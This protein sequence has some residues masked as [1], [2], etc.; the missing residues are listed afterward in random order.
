MA[1]TGREPRTDGASVHGAAA[2]QAQAHALFG[3]LARALLLLA[4]IAA[5]LWFL[6]R[7]QQV[8]LLLLLVAVLAIAVT[9]PVSMLE[10]R[11]GW[12]RGAAL[13][14]V[15]LALLAL[16][17]GLLW[18]LV[19][20]LLRE[21]PTLTTQIAQIAQIAEQAARQAGERFGLAEEA[22]GQVDRLLAWAGGA[23]QEAWRFAGSLVAGLVLAIV[24]VAM[25]LYVVADPRPLLAGVLRAMPPHLRGRTAEALARG[26]RMVVAWVVANALIGAIKAVA[27]FLFLTYMGVP[28]ALPWSLLAFFSALVPQIGFYLMSIP[29]IMM[30]FAVDPMTALWVGLYFWT[31]STLLGNF[32]APHIQGERMNLHPAY[33][34]GMTVAFGYAFGLL[35]VLIAAPVA[36]FLKAFFDAFYLERQPEDERSDERVEAILARKP[37]AAG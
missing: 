15:S 27:A 18:L 28:G 1:E 24:T 14:A 30:A 19:P 4:G 3:A 29:P 21:L 5:L 36:G 26:S 8:V 11:R 34:L 22:A 9:A 31:L 20:R 12:S 2:Y 32:V 7:I 13:A 25:V 10:R 16:G 35:G 23:A 17:A 6:S 33:L 37:E